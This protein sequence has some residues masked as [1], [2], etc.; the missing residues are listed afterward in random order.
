MVSQQVVC[1]TLTNPGTGGLNEV[2]VDGNTISEAT[3]PHYLYDAK[4]KKWRIA[5]KDKD[6]NLVFRNLQQNTLS[7]SGMAIEG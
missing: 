6:S 3:T 2:Y 1:H 5:G 4:N 7:N